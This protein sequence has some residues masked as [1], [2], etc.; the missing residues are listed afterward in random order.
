MDEGQV[1]KRLKQLI[2]DQESRLSDVVFNSDRARERVLREPADA[3]LLAKVMLRH[4][5]IPRLG[6]PNA[7]AFLNMAVLHLGKPGTYILSY[8][9]VQNR[10]RIFESDS[11][12]RVES[13]ILLWGKSPSSGYTRA[14]VHVHV[15]SSGSTHS[16]EIDQ[17]WNIQTERETGRERFGWTG[18]DMLSGLRSTQGELSDGEAL[19]VAFDFLR[20]KNQFKKYN[21]VILT[22][23]TLVRPYG[24]IYFYA[25]KEFVETGNIL[26]ALGG[27]GPFI[28]ERDTGL[29]FE[30]PA[31]HPV[32][33]WIRR[34]EASR[35]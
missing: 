9:P 7:P 1:F 22:D 4:F 14:E 11:I 2:G 5:L 18:Y 23:Q 26:Y 24:W 33:D 27:N 15:G 19:A 13:A 16:I 17:H 21:L 10:L 31:R 29:V 3:F 20:S 12:P 8:R 25:T 35:E 30:L 34:Y 32:E 6:M 28:V